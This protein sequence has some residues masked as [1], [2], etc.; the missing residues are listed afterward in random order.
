MTGRLENWFT[1]FS[2]GTGVFFSPAFIYPVFYQTGKG[3]LFSWD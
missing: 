3:G 2:R 1:S